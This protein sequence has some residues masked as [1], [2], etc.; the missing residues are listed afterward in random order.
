MNNMAKLLG[1]ILANRLVPHLDRIVSHSHSAFI[2]GRIIHDN[3]QYVQ[4]TIKHFH[5]SKTT[6]LFLKLDITKAFDNVWW[7]YLLELMEQLKFGADGEMPWLSYG[8]AHRH[9]FFSVVKWATP[10][11]MAEDSGKETHFH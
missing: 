7:E 2:K 1:K 9:G 5:N 6:M 10:S 3:F 4:G 8:A 11:S